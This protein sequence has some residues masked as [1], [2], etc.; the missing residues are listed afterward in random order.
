MTV[1]AVALWAKGAGLVALS[2]VDLDHRFRRAAPW[3]SHLVTQLLLQRAGVRGRLPLRVR[4]AD[5]THIQRPGQRSTDQRIHLGMDLQR[6]Q[7]DQVLVTG[8]ETGES[9]AH[10]PAVPGELLIGDRGLASRKGI[11]AVH[12]QQAWVLVRLPWDRLP[13][14]SAEGDG[15]V[16]A[17]LLG[18][19]APGASQEWAVQIPPTKKTPTIAGRLIAYR[20]T[21][22][23]LQRARKTRK[24]KGRKTYKKDRPARTLRDG[25]E[26]CAYLLLFTTL[27]V[28]HATTAQVLA[29][30]RLRWQIELLIKRLKSILRL[31]ELR[32]QTPEL[33]RT[34]IFAKLLLLVLCEDLCQTA[35]VFSP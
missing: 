24:R 9:L 5:A 27:P 12:Q 7:L 15:C 20:L 23:E 26:T 10:I 14:Q 19:L 4:L 16:L 29:L 35:E 13:L 6:M 8:V 32:A 21:P 33:A 17:T 3:V 11:A 28:T 25:L 22:D 30:Y 2:A 18:P 31:D 1:A 34:W